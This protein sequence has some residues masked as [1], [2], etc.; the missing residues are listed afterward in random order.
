A[1]GPCDVAETCDGVGN[2][3]PADILRDASS[4]CRPAQGDCDVAEHC[5]GSAPSCP[6]DRSKVGV[7][8]LTCQVDECLE[9][10]RH[11]KLRK[12]ADRIDHAVGMGRKPKPRWINQLTKLLSRCGVAQSAAAP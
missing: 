4:V 5:T 2:D 8:A 9:V 3:C 1:S 11:R 10:G 7:E 6:E 12:L